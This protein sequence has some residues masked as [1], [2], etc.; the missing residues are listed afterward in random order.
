LI[1]RL[2]FDAFAVHKLARGI[3]RIR[4]T[5]DDHTT[6]AFTKKVSNRGAVIEPVVNH[7]TGAATLKVPLVE[8]MRAFDDF[9]Q[10][11]GGKWRK[12]AAD[13]T[14]HG[15]GR[16]TALAEFKAS[17]SLRVKLKPCTAAARIAE[18]LKS[19]ERGYDWCK[20]RLSYEYEVRFEFIGSGG[21]TSVTYQTTETIDPNSHS[22]RDIHTHYRAPAMPSG[23][24]AIGDRF[25][26]RVRQLT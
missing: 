26:E 13:V 14:S 4:R 20:E 25:L 24:A 5:I 1:T 8:A 21:Q 19:R 12:L 11:E 16:C 22:E 2:L 3:P 10:G 18:N 17:Q 15:R 9:V 6:R 7:Y 23:F